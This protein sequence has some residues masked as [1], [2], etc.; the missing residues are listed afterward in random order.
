MA[1]C[2]SCACA[3]N[4]VTRSF[5]LDGDTHSSLWSKLV[6]FFSGKTTE[7]HLEQAIR[8][9]REDGELTAEEG[10]MLRSI[11]AL[12]EIRCRSS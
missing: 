3:P 9:A 12:D 2:I 6:S 5:F 11:L 7:D 1:C 8:E 10:S 4:H